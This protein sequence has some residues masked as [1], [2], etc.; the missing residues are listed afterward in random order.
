MFVHFTDYCI[1]SHFVKKKK[2]KIRGLK[3]YTFNIYIQYIDFSI[4]FSSL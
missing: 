3:T 2:K 4:Y 1:I